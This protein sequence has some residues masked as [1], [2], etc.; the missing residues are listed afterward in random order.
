LGS[1]LL[2]MAKMPSNLKYSKTV[3]KHAISSAIGS[4][5]KIT[6]LCVL[7][8]SQR[9]KCVFAG[10]FSCSNWQKKH[11]ETWM[12]AHKLSCNKV[13]S[14]FIVSASKMTH[15]PCTFAVWKGKYGQICILGEHFFAQNGKKHLEASITL[16][17]LQGKDTR[18]KVNVASIS[19]H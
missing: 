18:Y 3:I 16:Q 12:P 17:K 4:A 9:P 10:L 7:R 6:I 15:L 1:F 2:Q 5:P 8:K 14:S 13:K 19:T 11:V